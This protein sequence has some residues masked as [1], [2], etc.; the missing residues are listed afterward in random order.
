[1]F[2]CTCFW[3]CAV[4]PECIYGIWTKSARGFLHCSPSDSHSRGSGFGSGWS[5]AFAL[6]TSRWCPIKSQL[7]AR[8]IPHRDFC[9]VSYDRPRVRADRC[10]LLVDSAITVAILSEFLSAMI[11]GTL[12]FRLLAEE[13]ILQH[14]EKGKEYSRPLWFLAVSRTVFCARQVLRQRREEPFLTLVNS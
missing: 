9:S 8:A 7:S 1:M 12:C 4:G 2:E 10:R 11:V 13:L 3:V 6:A 5:S 14:G